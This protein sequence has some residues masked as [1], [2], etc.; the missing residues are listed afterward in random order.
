MFATFGAFSAIA[1]PILGACFATWSPADLTALLTLVGVFF[2]TDFATS[3]A[4]VRIVFAMSG[5]LSA[6]ALPTAGAFF[7]ISE[8]SPPIMSVPLF[9]AM[10]PA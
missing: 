6:T 4:F 3:G 10:R 8:T 1:L 2:A 9:F 7:A 5:A